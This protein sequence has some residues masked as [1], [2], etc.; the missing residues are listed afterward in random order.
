MSRRASRRR[1]FGHP[2]RW[3]KLIMKISPRTPWNRDSRGRQNALELGFHCVRTHWIRGLI[4]FRRARRTRIVMLMVPV[5]PESGL[6]DR[7]ARTD[8]GAGVSHTSRR[9][10]FYPSSKSETFVRQSIPERN[11]GPSSGSI[12]R[13]ME[14]EAV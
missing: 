11:L 5:G 13:L 10:R 1:E 3:L 9:A 12:W 6:R 14:S 4:A 8:G 7:A 2:G